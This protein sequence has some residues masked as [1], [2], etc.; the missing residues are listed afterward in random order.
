MNLSKIQIR[1]VILIIIL[2]LA[3]LLRLSDLR[4]S[5][6]GLNQ[7]EASN[8]WSAYC[9]LKTG[10]DSAGASWPIYYMRGL[11]GNSN[12]LLTYMTIPFQVIGGLNVYT[13]R[14]PAAFCGV[15]AVWLIYYVAKKLFDI[16]TGLA[17]AALL[18]VNPWHLQLSRWG[19]DAAIAPL[20][21]LVPLAGLLAANLPAGIDKDKS[22][23]P[24]IACLS[25]ILAGIGCFGYFAVRLFVPAFIFGLVIFNL[26][27]WWRTLKTKKGALATALF[28]IGFMAIFGQLLYLHIFHSEN[29]GRHISF[30]SNWVGSANLMDSLKNVPLRYIKHFGL[31]FLFTHG[32]H[33]V[34]QGPP[35]GGEYHWYELPLMIAGAVVV[36]RKFITS[37][38]LRIIVAFVLTYP[39]GDCL[40]WEIESLHALRSSPGLCALSL[41]G[42]VGLIAAVKWLWKQNPN[43]TKIGLIVFALLVI[44]FNTRFLYHFFGEFNRR[45][46]VFHRFHVDLLEACDWLKPHFDDF[47]AV[48][49][50]SFSFNMPYVITVVALDYDPKRWFA[51]PIEVIP[52][53][54]DFYLRYGKMHF[55][56]NFSNFSISELRKK[57]APDRLLLILRP[58]EFNIIAETEKIKNPAEYVIH[59]IYDPEKK[60]V[61]WLC[62]F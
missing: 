7:D 41:L 52:S 19:H 39:M 5:P 54:Y 37:A 43:N 14:M 11:G 15:F 59:K 13:T 62:R 32:D 18:A 45:T 3:A 20:L 40:G 48:Y 55:L 51:E 28:F 25:G 12:T 50:S 34:I 35:I 49:I 33:F 17:V 9:L 44:G 16:D 42:A 53:E 36:L 60:E 56:Y 1:T 21:G 10:K 46:E 47:D 61:L 57:V 30:Q 22:P 38:S 31:D 8:A 23:R 26:P 6:P 4:I 58:N 2:L 24:I 27:L 29:I